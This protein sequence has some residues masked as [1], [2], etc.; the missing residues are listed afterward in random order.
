MSDFYESVTDAYDILKEN[1]T[2]KEENAS[3]RREVNALEEAGR[4]YEELKSAFQMKDDFSDYTI[5]A[6]HVMTESLGVLF[7]VLKIDLGT[8]DG[9]DPSESVTYPVLDAYSNLVDGYCRPTPC[10]GRFCL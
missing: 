5:R 9:V 6:A 2:L 4:K 1:Q 8:R 3:L 10:P 7:D